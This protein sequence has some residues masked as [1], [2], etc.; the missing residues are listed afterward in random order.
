MDK[1]NVNL[2]NCYG[3]E[4]MKYEFDFSENNAMA[5]YARNGLMKTSFSKT[6]KKIQ[7]NKVNEIR[8]EIFNKPGVADILKD[9]STINPDSVFV[10][11][12][13]E[14]Y[15][16]SNSITDLLVNDNIKTQIKNVLKLREKFLKELEK[17][18]GLK[19]S[20]TS[21]CKKI[22]ELEPTLIKDLNF[23]LLIFMVFRFMVSFCFLS[24]LL[25]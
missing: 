11:K 18:S 6:F 3:I 13:F 12:S 20:K 14:S 17:S 25:I 8:D 4:K 7:E 9:G 5:I 1:L 15:Y 21:S 22:Y 23:F 24:F 16:E 2:R 10:I 19:I